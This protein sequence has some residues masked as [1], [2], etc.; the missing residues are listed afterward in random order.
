MSE[1]TK[2]LTC[3]IIMP[4]SSIDSCSSEHWSEVKNIFIES[5][6]SIEKYKFTTRLVSDA[7]EVGVIQ[8]RIVQNIYSSD[9]IICDVSAKNP[10]VMFELGMRLAFDKPTIIVKDDITSYTFDTGIIE[11][12]E[13]PRDLRFSKIVEFKNRLAEKVIATYNASVNSHDHSPFLKNFGEF[14][15]TNLK[16]TEVSANQLIIN[17][18]SD[19]QEQIV[20]IKS[21]AYPKSIGT[22]YTIPILSENSIAVSKIRDLA[23]ESIKRSVLMYM[24]ANNLPLSKELI[25]NNGLS[26]FVKSNVILPKEYLND[27]YL[28]KV[29]SLIISCMMRNTSS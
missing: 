8:K 4:I 24:S 18:L 25:A 9:I 3:G 26:D 28:K 15:V 1:T 16:E 12:L 20:S 7:D 22:S 29:L 11:H 2:E 6:S 21:Q 14:K 5:I 23:E 10:N 13:Y 19:M 27:N 17:M